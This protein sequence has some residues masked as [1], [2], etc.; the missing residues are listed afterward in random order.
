[1]VDDDGRIAKED[2]ASHKEKVLS[3]VK[4]MTQ[5]AATFRDF[6]AP[7]KEKT[8]FMPCEAVSSALEILSAQFKTEEIAVSIEEHEH[9]NAFGYKNEFL[10]VLL[11]IL[12]NAR[13]AIKENKIQ[14]GKIDVFIES[15][16]KIGTIK[17]RDNAGGIPDELLPNKLFESY[18]STKGQNG[19]GIG[20]QIAKTIIEEHNGGKLWA[21]NIGGGAEFVI[22]IPIFKIN[23]EIKE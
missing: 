12:I 7:S 9:F 17:I 20:L 16:N 15:N 14:N 18:V 2:I 3:Q 5:T 11:N 1:M 21:H 10:Q 4:N 23:H 13:D 19:T 22:E 6:F 8:V